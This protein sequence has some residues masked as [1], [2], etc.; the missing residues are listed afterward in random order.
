M[1]PGLSPELKERL[2]RSDP[3]A[4]VM[5]EADVT[6]AE[7]LR[8]RKDQWNAADSLTGL[9]VYE[10]GRVQLSGSASTLFESTTG[11]GETTD[12]NGVAPLDVA[13][14]NWTASQPDDIEVREITAHLNPKRST[15]NPI[16]VAKWRLQL[17][18]VTH[19][20]RARDDAGV[21]VDYHRVTPLHAP[22][23]KDVAGSGA[24]NVTFD[25]STLSA[26]PRPKAIRPALVVDGQTFEGALDPITFLVIMALKSDGSAAGN[27]AWTHDA[28]ISSVSSAAGTMKG[29]RLATSLGPPP[30]HAGDYKVTDLSTVPRCAVKAG[31]FVTATLGFTGAGNQI[32]LGVTPTA[33]VQFRGHAEVPTG[34]SATFEVLAD[35][36]VTWRTYLD[37]Q[38]TTD[39]V[40]VGKRQTYKLRCTLTTNGAGSL[41]PTL[42]D[43]GVREVTR[44]DLSDVAELTS[45][46]WGIDP[47]TLK[48]EIPEAI[49]EARRDGERDFADAITTLLSQ[50]AVGKLILRTWVGH[51]DLSRDKWLHLDDWL[52]DDTEPDGASIRLTCV[53]VLALLRQAL[54]AYTAEVALTPDGDSANPGSWTD[55]GAGSTN[56][57]QSID[58]SVAGAP[59]DADYVQSPVDP[60][61]A[62]YEVSL[63]NISDPSTSSYHR[64]EYRYSK[65]AAAGKTIELTVELRQGATVKASK[66]HSDI[67]ELWAKGSFDLTKAEADSITDYNDLRIRFKANVGGAGG[68]RRARVSFAHAV[69]LAHREPLEK[70]NL[71]PKAIYDDLIATQARDLLA[72]YRG[73]GVENTTDVLTK[74]I[75]ESDIKVELDALAFIAGGGLTSS[76]GRVL[77]AEMYPSGGRGLAALFPSEEITV[78]A[79]S[80]GYRQRTPEVFVR[81]NY[82]FEEQRFRQE[83][84]GFNSTALTN[85]GN[86]RVDPPQFIDDEVGKYIPDDPDLANRLVTRQADALGLGLN[87]WRIRLNYAHPWLMPG[88]LVAVQTD[89]FVAYDPN[90]GRALKGMLWAIGVVSHYQ[91]P[92]RGDE[93][94]VWIQS[95]SD[96][97][98][99]G[100][101]GKRLGFA[102]PE[103]LDVTV[104]IADTGVPTVVV[105]T[106]DA[107][108]VRIA[109]SEAGY[110]TEATT[111]AAAVVATDSNGIATSTPTGI[112]PGGTMF[113]T[114]FAYETA[115][116]A[117]SES[118]LAKGIAY[119][120]YLP[121]LSLISVWYFWRANRLF[122]QWNGNTG[123]GSVKV[124]TSTT[125]Q[126]A[127]GSG[128]ASNPVAG[129]QGVFDAG[130]FVYGDTVYVTVTPYS[131]ASAAGT[132][133]PA[134]M[135]STRLSE[136]EDQTDETTGKRKRT[137]QFDDS[138]YALKASDTAGKETDDDL[139]IAS[140]KTLKVGTVASPGTLTKTPARIS[141]AELIPEKNTTKWDI[142]TG[143]LANNSA[144]ASEFFYGSFFLP[145][146][147]T[148]T[149]VA[150]RSYRAA[151]VDVASATLYRVGDSG[152]LTSLATFIWAG[153][154]G[155]ATFTASLSELVGTAPYV[156]EVELNGFAAGDSR[157]VWYE[158]TYT[159]PSYDKGL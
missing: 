111:R 156:L 27:V 53:S 60:S 90:A 139:F 123:V 70:V 62:E 2:Q 135:N 67:S 146:G 23:L 17:W 74:T 49:I 12:L 136:K 125:S 46:R 91:D 41:T 84:R 43:M 72:R 153:G 143:Y 55:E 126:P 69:I 77:F 78:L 88:D 137:A 94:T 108:S 120:V 16:E 141:F 151:P 5:I 11:S 103:I 115:D 68:S 92:L 31:A 36:A 159:M 144:G 101:S 114:V 64:V 129:N 117:G 45:A 145:A 154:S 118:S 100:E 18:A 47:V 76:Q 1:R 30:V 96:I 59:G 116:G 89:K 157:F 52:I 37:G 58:E 24:G 87:L 133:G 50:N 105:K 34:T 73:P 9:T 63:S 14:L 28:G 110:P 57:F 106:R 35:D 104:Q 29:V 150:L 147:V 127:A 15:S 155:Y 79:V 81:H 8:Q 140:T 85:L 112:A 109:T 65:D 122:I 75:D 56:I 102:L 93:L 40:G 44:T 26:K 48:G 83:A 21:L 128:T 54:P 20:I 13:R 152:S 149:Q 82:H 130:T 131:G 138:K 4:R 42:V 142:G 3:T 80:P 95:Y 22:L 134:H 124:A 71:S 113:V 32:D 86:A 33:D 107:L 99:H 6:A 148:I 19:V 38:F 51:P 39:L 132:Q 121:T 98:A 25:F 61:N 119:H 66:V 7:D 97:I 10:D 158:L